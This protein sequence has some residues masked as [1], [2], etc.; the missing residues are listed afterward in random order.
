MTK[1]FKG[2]L[3][4]G[5]V[6]ASLVIALGPG[7]M[8]PV[9]GSNAGSKALQENSQGSDCPEVGSVKVCGGPENDWFRDVSRDFA[10]GYTYSPPS[11]FGNRAALIVQY[12]PTNPGT[13]PAPI[14]LIPPGTGRIIDGPN[15]EHFNAVYE[16]AGDVIAVGFT[17]SINYPSYDALIVDFDPS[18]PAI[19]NQYILGSV[20][21]ASDEVFW[22]VTADANYVYAVGFTTYSGTRDALLARYR[23]NPGTYTLTIAPPIIYLW[24][25]G[26]DEFIA[27]TYD[28]SDPNFIYAVGQTDTPP[29]FGNRDAW[30]VKFDRVNYPN[31]VGEMVTGGPGLDV[32]YDVTN[33]LD[34][35]P[36]GTASVYAVGSYGSPVNDDALM[37]RYTSTNAAFTYD[38]ANSIIY[39]GAVNNRDDYF[40]AVTNNG[41]D[42]I[43]AVGHTN[44]G[45]AVNK[46]ALIVRYRQ[47]VGTLNRKIL[48]GDKDDEFWGVTHTGSYIYPVGYTNSKGAGND[49]A[50]MLQLADTIE[51]TTWDNCIYENIPLFE[52]CPISEN[53]YTPPENFEYHEYIGLMNVPIPLLEEN[54]HID[55]VKSTKD[56]HL[57]VGWNLVSFP[58]TSENTTPNKLF[59]DKPPMYYWTGGG[60]SVPDRNKPVQDN[61]GYW[62]KENKNITV[63]VPL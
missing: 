7:S 44:S 2:I 20:N 4:S 14:P 30:I 6:I 51:G 60:Y 11:M 46:D 21:T 25:I 43:Y 15:D 59:P 18:N 12:N 22:G 32:F 37:V 9:K 26:Y 54:C 8:V 31:V 27:V 56:I 40:G 45:P 24:G 17:N 49:D 53:H 42:M 36:A 61:I 33:Y 5:L 47:N 16:D 38:P 28:L 39:S 3:L 23:R 13:P 52:N 29:T 50:L 10:V 55:E 34:G 41:A 19:S 48:K 1:S 62:V 57:V 58:L 35:P 63:T